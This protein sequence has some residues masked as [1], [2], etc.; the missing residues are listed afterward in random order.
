[1]TDF[2][3]IEKQSVQGK[4]IFLYVDNYRSEDWYGYHGWLRRT[5]DPIKAQYNIDYGHKDLLSM[6][7]P[8]DVVFDC[9][10]N[11]GYTTVLFAKWV[12]ESGK[13]LAFEPNQKNTEIIKK[14]VELN[15]LNN[16]II[17]RRAL[18]NEKGK[19]VNFGAE[20]VGR[21]G[22]E[23]ETDVLD[24]YLSYKPNFIKVDVEGYELPLIQG[25]S[26]ILD[27]DVK[28]EIEVHL[29]DTTGVN[30]KT[31]YGFNPDDIWKILKE[32]NFDVRAL[33][34]MKSG[35][36]NVEFGDEPQGVVY[37]TKRRQ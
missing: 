20:M 37:C 30:M 26:K 22:E 19:I 5:K 9:G 12:G 7:K 24:S 21:E 28:L 8:G 31:A 2:P 13:V 3:Y 35:R 10:A 11:E 4:E 25:A 23:V 1:M 27:T 15:N 34:A 32:K 36:H 16:V 6:I 33:R 18:S 17:V 14:N 29:S